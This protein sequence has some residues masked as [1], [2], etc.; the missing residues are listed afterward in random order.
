MQC[1][2]IGNDKTI[3]CYDVV[4]TEEERRE[5][6]AGSK[7]RKQQQKGPITASPS[8]SLPPLYEVLYTSQRSMPYTSCL[9]DETVT[10]YYSDIDVNRLAPPQMLMD[11]EMEG[12]SSRWPMY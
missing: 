1:L 9:T 2:L 4:K 11:R 7:R 8:V 3:L 10:D 12:V 5:R 6:R